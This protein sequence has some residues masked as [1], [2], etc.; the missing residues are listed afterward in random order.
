MCKKT[1]HF[2]YIIDLFKLFC[3]NNWLNWHV[4]FAA[5]IDKLSEKVLPKKMINS[6]AN[7]DEETKWRRYCVV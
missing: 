1:N 2:F 3:C 4:E 6:G 7:E 5:I